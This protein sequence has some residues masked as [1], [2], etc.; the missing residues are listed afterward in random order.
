MIKPNYKF[1]KNNSLDIIG[2]CLHEGQLHKGV[3]KA[4][5]IIRKAGLIEA[6]KLLGWNI[7]DKGNIY[8][9]DCIV[10]KNL[11]LTKYKYANKI[12]DDLLIG[13]FNRDLA[14]SV[15]ESAK[16]NNFVLSLGG[17]HSIAAGSITG[18]KRAYKNLKVIWVDAHA[19][20]N[21]PETTLSDS[22]HGCPVGHLIG[23]TPKGT[24]PGFDWLEPSL[25]NIDIAYIGL[26]HLDKG[27]I[28]FLRDNNIKHYDM[29]LVTEKGIGRVMFEIFEYFNSDGKNFRNSNDNYSEYLDKNVYAS[30]QNNPNL[31]KY[32][33]HLSF[34]IDGIDI[35][36]VQQT[37]TVCRG[38]L[39]DREA[40]YLIRKCAASQ[41]LVGM[42]LVELNTTLGDNLTNKER[43]YTHG[44]FLYI[45]GSQTVCL[46][47]ELAQSGLGFRQIL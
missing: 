36:Y 42:D 17:D 25:S 38:G 30:F 24:V 8:P 34:D 4:P 21:N 9:N 28:N 47:V 15:E 11:D 19:D 23:N 43:I 45:K 26:R 7:N 31:L 5:D 2:A 46:T 3:E 37:G 22:Y 39:T 40:N 32:P 10:D 41:A 13:A 35:A 44:D 18:M 29:D 1:I 16:S 12:R 20:I 6:A 14:K 27:E 33:L